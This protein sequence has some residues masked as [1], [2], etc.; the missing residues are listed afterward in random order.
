MRV[1][2]ASSDGKVI[3]QHFGKATQFLIFELNKYSYKFIELRINQPACA[4]SEFGSHN[5]SRLE[6]TMNKISDCSVVLCSRIGTGIKELLQKK[7]IRAIEAPFPIED[8][9][10]MI[11]RRQRCYKTKR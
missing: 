3:N 6:Q 7:G 11:M 10:K 9:L 8:E 4:A 5:E 2:V 1:A